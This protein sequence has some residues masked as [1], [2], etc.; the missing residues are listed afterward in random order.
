[1]AGDLYVIIHVEAHEFFEREG[2]NIYC[3][4]PISMVQ[5]ALGA[6]LD[7]PT[8][9]GKK[10][11]VIKKGSQTG[12]SITLKEEGVPT[13]RGHGRGNMIVTLQVL[14]PTNLS[15]EQEELLKKFAQLAG[16]DANQPEEE[17]FFKK[18]LH[19]L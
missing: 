11:I 16:D 1:M 13:L 5:A 15:K 14:T 2:S 3:T 18:L 6:K 17:G 19:N 12:Q 8:I 4:L 10:N 7:V 9:H